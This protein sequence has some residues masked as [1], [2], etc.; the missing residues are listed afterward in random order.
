VAND[1]MDLVESDPD[2]PFTLKSSSS[3]LIKKH[4]IL[5]KHEHTT[6][7]PS[8]LGF[9]YPKASPKEESNPLED[10]IKS[11]DRKILV[12]DEIILSF[13]SEDDEQLDYKLQ[14]RALLIHKFKLL[15]T[16]TSSLS[17]PSK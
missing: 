7:S 12:L 9:N 11:I 8:P 3:K 1:T 2:A 6:E 16:P 4:E 10:E 14:K 5:I 15:N 17:T 13:S